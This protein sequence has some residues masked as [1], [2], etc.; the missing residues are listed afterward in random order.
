MKKWLFFLACLGI[1][2]ALSGESLAGR[3]VATLEPVQTVQISSN[4]RKIV[5][6]TD[7]GAKGSGKDLDDAL[8]NLHEA[9]SAF[10]FLDT[11]DYLL[12]APELCHLIPSLQDLLR[13]SCSIILMKGKPDME[14][15]GAFLKIHEPPVTMKDY[16]AGV[17]DL[18]T[19]NTTGEEMRLVS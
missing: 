17:H 6:Q 13:P 15:V 16:L 4:G 14:K 11:A 12:V 7:T 18:P 10:V 3:D 2:A 8:Q 5:L 9:A 1:V 19:L